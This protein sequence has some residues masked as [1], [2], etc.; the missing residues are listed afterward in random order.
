MYLLFISYWQHKILS[1]FVVQMPHNSSEW[2]YYDWAIIVICVSLLNLFHS[3][4]QTRAG[5]LSKRMVNQTTDI[6]K[7]EA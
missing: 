6:T 1:D 4:Y 2:Y 3:K 7:S 5:H